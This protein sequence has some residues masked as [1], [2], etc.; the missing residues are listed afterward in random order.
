MF[1]FVVLS[2]DSSSQIIIKLYTFFVKSFNYFLLPQA[3]VRGFYLKFKL[4]ICY[5]NGFTFTSAFIF[6]PFF[7]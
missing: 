4:H 3:H 5:S 6:V 2:N 7:I 1:V